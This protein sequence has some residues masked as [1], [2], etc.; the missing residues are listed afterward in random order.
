MEK[1][2]A[3]FLLIVFGL[4]LGYSVQW[5]VA[6][7]IINLPLSLDEL[8]KRLQK[9]ALLFFVPATYFG[10]IWIVD[11]RDASLVLFPL[12]EVFATILGGG[13]ALLVSKMLHLPPKQTGALFT[14]GAFTNV[15]SIG[16][17]VSFLFLGEKAF[18]LMT[19][20]KLFQPITHF[21]IGFPVAKSYSLNSSQKLSPRLF[22]RHLKRDPFILAGLSSIV[23][24][25]VP[26]LIGIPRPAFFQTVN[27]VLIPFS[28]ILLLVSI[29]LAIR[30]SRIKTYLRECLLISG[31]KFVCVP[32]C[33]SFLAL[34]LGYRV[35]DDGLPIKV[36]MILSS[37]PVAFNAL[38]A[39]SLYDLELDMANSCF[40]FTTSALLVTLPVLYA[41]LA[42]V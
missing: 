42:S 10:A 9:S 39:S 14:C 27:A 38:V 22:F 33:A 23:A 24:G 32:I 1:F 36:I 35:I 18:A 11:I 21:A 30:F 16:G 3:S 7:H 6:L 41:L 19:I 20:Y 40:L 28:T 26:N 4:L 5:L 37:M 15:G 8:R 25:G 13:L 12:F 2:V 17:L 31:I 29:G 34:F